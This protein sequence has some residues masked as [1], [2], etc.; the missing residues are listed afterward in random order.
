MHKMKSFALILFLVSSTSCLFAQDEVSPAPLSTDTALRIV[1]LNPFFT[2]HV[3]SSLTYPLQVN[4]N[5]G[6]YFWYLKNSPVGF[7]I[8]K[9]NGLLS[10][11]AEKAYFLSG[12][13]K[14]DLNYK[15][16]VGVQ[17]MEKPAEKI[18]TSFTIVFYNTEIMPSR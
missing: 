6:K 5:E 10:F 15:V 14:Y 12:K 17:N 7:R 13:L 11:K 8:N 18:D 9:D 16:V 1:D 3:D 4:R 2:L